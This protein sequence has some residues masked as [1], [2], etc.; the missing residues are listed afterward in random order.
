MLKIYILTFR[1]EYDLKKYKC[2]K[3][4]GTVRGMRVSQPGGFLVAVAAVPTA[5]LQGEVKSTELL[6]HVSPFG[7]LPV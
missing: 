4:G 2:A 1:R 6:T 3:V 7:S 5:V